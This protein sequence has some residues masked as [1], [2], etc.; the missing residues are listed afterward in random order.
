[1]KVSKLGES[2]KRGWG[3]EGKILKLQVYAAVWFTC[4][5]KVVFDMLESILNWF[6]D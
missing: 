4:A 5:S 6:T 3:R 2:G 1:M